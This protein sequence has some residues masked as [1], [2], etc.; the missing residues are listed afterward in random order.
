[1]PRPSI[2]TRMVRCAESALVSAIEICNKPGLEYREQTFA[3]LVVNAWEIFLKA[4]IVQLHDGKIQSIYRRQKNSIRYARNE[5]GEPITITLDKAIDIANPPG[6]VKANIK[7]LALVRNQIAHLG[8]VQSDLQLAILQFGTSSIKNFIDLSRRWFDH[9]INLPFFV[10]VGFIGDV[11]MVRSP[12]FGKQKILL[13]AL[14]DL[15]KAYQGTESEYTVALNVRVNLDTNLEGG[16]SVGITNDPTAPEVRI[17]DTEFFEKYS[18]SYYDL[19]NYCKK[20]YSD[21]KQDPHFRS[22]MR[23]I[24][25]DINCASERRL[26]PKNP[27]SQTGQW[28]YSWEPIKERLDHEYQIKSE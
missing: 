27:K 3:L 11:S 17:S 12:S 14:H 24:K 1:M 18:S 2:S 19:I 23:E 8:I 9:I 5:L 6:E 16:G 26:N 4:R 21:F 22:L 20:R 7:G 13:K 28:F 25:T 15:T 10:P